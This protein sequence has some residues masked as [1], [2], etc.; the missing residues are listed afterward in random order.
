MADG[1]AEQNL[2]QTR[3]IT[4]L[5]VI[6]L[7]FSLWEKE[8]HLSKENIP[9]RRLMH[10]TTRMPLDKHSHPLLQTIKT[11][12]SGNPRRKNYKICHLPQNL[13]HS[14]FPMTL[15][16]RWYAILLILSAYCTCDSC[17]DH[18]WSKPCCTQSNGKIRIKVKK[19][20]KTELQ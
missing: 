7:K 1:I 4:K 17:E 16:T 2:V 13:E 20:Q 3:N 11:C 15:F 6:W 5:T 12:Q 18:L 8:E 10:W 14:C 9:R 19:K